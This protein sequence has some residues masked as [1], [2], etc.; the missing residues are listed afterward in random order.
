MSI[1][2][3]W[4]DKELLKLVKLCNVAA[5][6]ETPQK[7]REAFQSKIVQM[8]REFRT[9]TP[10]CGAGHGMFNSIPSPRCQRDCQHCRG[11]HGHRWYLWAM[12]VILR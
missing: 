1:R 5:D 3:P 11:K 7:Q 8:L 6:P 4:S 12:P 10:P 9:S 2:T